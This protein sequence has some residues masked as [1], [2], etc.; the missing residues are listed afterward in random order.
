M[1]NLSQFFDFIVS[2]FSLTDIIHKASNDSIWSTMVLPL[3][4]SKVNNAVA[5]A[6]EVIQSLDTTD[7]LRVLF[8]DVRPVIGFIVWTNLFPVLGSTRY[9]L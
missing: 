6:S 3:S 7:T 9:F 4:R 5:H 8:L 1:V 2:T